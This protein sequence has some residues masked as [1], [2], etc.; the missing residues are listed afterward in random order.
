MLQRN[1]VN[2]VWQW[3]DMIRS[4][5]LQMKAGKLKNFMHF[6]LLQGPPEGHGGACGGGVPCMG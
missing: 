1:Q 2:F 6:G 3:Q 4:V 5:E